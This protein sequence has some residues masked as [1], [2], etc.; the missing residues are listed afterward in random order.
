VTGF[1]PREDE[2]SGN[3]AHP[4]ELCT[5]GGVTYLSVP[6]G[7]VVPTQPTSINF[8]AVTL[9]DELRELI[10]ANSRAVKLITEDVQNRIRSKYSIEDEQY[11]SR[12]GVGVAL[13]AYTFLAGEQEA[14]L[15]FGAYVEECRQHGK[16][17]RAELGL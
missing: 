8:S 6:E 7:Y 4:L 14:L 10:K 13:G 11:F 3:T 9:T 1:T 17:Q 12:I 16:T 15:A 2:S 5:I